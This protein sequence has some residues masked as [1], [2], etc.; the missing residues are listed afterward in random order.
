M[1]LRGLVT[2]A[3]FAAALICAVGWYH[4][5]QELRQAR[6]AMVADTLDPIWGMLSRLPQCRR[7]FL[8]QVVD[9]LA[10]IHRH[11]DTGC[12]AKPF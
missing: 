2:A 4:A 6:Y 7:V 12:L 1:N 9:R 10:H 8:Q 11:R 3:A 5:H